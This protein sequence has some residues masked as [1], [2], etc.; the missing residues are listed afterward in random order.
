MENLLKFYRNSIEM[1]SKFY[2][3]SIERKNGEGREARK[4]K[5]RKAE[6]GGATTNVVEVEE[7]NQAG[8]RN[9]V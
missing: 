3:T 5:Q 7:T 8:S 4:E 2:Q 9:R 6:G 1:R